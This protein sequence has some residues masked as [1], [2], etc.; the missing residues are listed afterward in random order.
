MLLKDFEELQFDICEKLCTRLE[1]E[2]KGR[3]EFDRVGAR[4]KLD[5][6]QRMSLH[7][8]FQRPGGSP[9]RLLLRTLWTE[10]T[11][12]TVE[13]FC[14]ALREIGL[15]RIAVSLEP[16]RYIESCRNQE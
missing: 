6:Y 14:E 3:F 2:R 1:K 13:T 16:F 4:F 9:S 7:N 15:S 8:E 12:L 10:N 5:E 11:E